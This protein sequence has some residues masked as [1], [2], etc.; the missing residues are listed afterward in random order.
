MM[1]KKTITI[2]VK[3]P[4]DEE[5][6]NLIKPLIPKP[7]K[8]EKGDTYKLTKKDKK[9]I[10]ESIEVPI[11]EK[12]IE[13]TEVIKETPITTE[14]VREVASKITG[15]EIA[16]KL[17]ELEGEDRLDASAI[18]NLDEEIRKYAP[19]KHT[20]VYGSLSSSDTL[21]DSNYDYI[22]HKGSATVYT[23][24][25][26]DIEFPSECW[27]IIDGNYEYVGNATSS[28]NLI[29]LL[30]TL[31]L[32]TFSINGTTVS[33]EGFHTYGK[34]YPSVVA[35]SA[36]SSSSLV[37]DTSSP[38]SMPNIYGGS[39]NDM[40][41]EASLS[42]NSTVQQQIA[43]LNYSFWTFPAG[44]IIHWLH[45]VDPPGDQWN[46]L[47]ADV[48]AR[49]KDWETIQEGDLYNGG[50]PYG[51][52]FFQEYIEMMDLMPNTKVALAVNIS[53]PLIPYSNALID[54]DAVDI[55][56]LCDELDIA[57]A[58]MDA[59]GREVWLWEIGMEEVTNIND[60]LWANPGGAETG[61]EVF[62][63]ILTHVNSTHPVSVLE[64]L[65]AITPDALLSIDAQSWENFP[66]DY[67]DWT[68]AVSVL[69]IDCIRQY[70]E[71]DGDI[72]T[73]ELARA[74]IA[75]YQGLFD[76]V[77][78]PRYNGKKVFISQSVVKTQAAIKNTVAHGMTYAE[79]AMLFH[80]QNIL[81]SEK[82][83]GLCLFATHHLFNE[84]GG[85]TLRP[86]YHYVKRLGELYSDTQTLISATP[87]DPDTAS[88]LIIQPIKDG[89]EIR[90]GV[91]NPTANTYTIDSLIIDGVTEPTY[92]VTQTYSTDGGSMG[93][94]ATNV[95]ESVMNFRPYS[96]S[97]ITYNP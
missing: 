61:E 87:N 78:H 2:K 31:N 5:L 68:E 33:A 13:K 90:I 85:F 1:D 12:I 64:H 18:K 79:T 88:N 9:E 53:L 21:V 92:S 59:I 93:T 67:P 32:G 57:V 39:A 35:D 25:I 22:G 44:A 86:Q 69:D 38:V 10:A 95:T 4:T 60:D 7:I 73:Y 16:D 48:E 43:D 27:I 28:S 17:E 49:G 70:Y 71:F 30:N 89:T 14:I 94:D 51:R 11:V 63:K 29:T 8:G 45:Y 6:T 58:S 3:K 96:F 77:N 56:A 15:T 74:R 83:S 36:P 19:K 54:W 76:F 50:V 97:V 40:S 82:V 81:N 91:L 55:G 65:R 75:E 80:E 46:A 72:D 41:L 42:A 47:Q 26:T 24:D 37:V 23:Y 84:P 62:V 52:E 34:L 20:K 66:G